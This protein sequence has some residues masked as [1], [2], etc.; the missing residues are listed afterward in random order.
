MRRVHAARPQP[1]GIDVAKGAFAY[2]AVAL[3]AAGLSVLAAP[4][5]ALIVERRSLGGFGISALAGVVLLSLWLFVIRRVQLRLAMG[6]AEVDAVG[7]EPA[8]AANFEA[9]NTATP[10]PPAGT[11]DVHEPIERPAG[12]DELSSAGLPRLRTV[13]HQFGG[14]VVLLIAVTALCSALLTYLYTGEGGQANEFAAKAAG[15]QLELMRDSS[16]QAVVAYRTIERLVALREVR[17]R[18]V[19]AKELRANAAAAGQREAFAIW[20]HEARRS[21]LAAEAIANQPAPDP[22]DAQSKA[23]VSRVFA[24]ENGPD[25]DPSFPAKLFI[26]STIWMAAERLALWDA[27]DDANTAS[28]VRA[29][30]LLA[31]ATFFAIALYLFGQ[32]LSMRRDPAAGYVLSGTAAALLLGGILVAGYGLKHEVPPVERMVTLP[33][34]CRSGDEDPELTIA[35]AAATCFAR[36]ELLTARA[37]NLD[38]YKSARKAYATATQ[39]DLRPDFTLAHYRSIRTMSQQATPQRTES[40][41]VVDRAALKAITDEERRVIEDLE[42]RDRAVPVSLREAFGFHEY[43]RAVDTKNAALLDDAVANLRVA[44]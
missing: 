16:R 15:Q 13:H 42:D 25:D 24:G 5:V 31:A 23:T 17:L 7:K 8:A 2:I 37:R 40:I 1:A 21:Q 3:V 36:A 19:A 14:L 4:W 27:Y 12:L 34:T 38:D 29:D 44:A 11:D 35:D 28:E 9:Q 10:V 39:D 22:T 30:L 41:S 6:G 20:D 32:S 33:E 43:L 26:G 18:T